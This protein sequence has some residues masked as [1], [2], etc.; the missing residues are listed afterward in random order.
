MGLNPLELNNLYEDLWAVGDLLLTEASLDVLKDEYRPW[1]KLRCETEIHERNK[2]EDL[3][4]LRAYQNREDIEVYVPVL[5][6]ILKLFGEAIHES[7]MRTMGEYL[8]ATNG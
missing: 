7:L 4:M 6:D 8:E 5:L 3:V 1:A 2:T